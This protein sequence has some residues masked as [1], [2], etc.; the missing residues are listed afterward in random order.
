MYINTAKILQIVDYREFAHGGMVGKWGNGG[1]G[2]G[3]GCI[4]A[5]M[6]DCVVAWMRGCMIE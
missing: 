1:L 5:W 3:E 2:V 6:H 4:G